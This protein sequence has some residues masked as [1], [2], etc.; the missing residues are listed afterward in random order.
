MTEQD[1]AQ[2]RLAFSISEFCQLH[3]L[4]RTTYYQME[5]EGKAPRV[6]RVGKRVLISAE[7]AADWR[8]AMERKQPEAA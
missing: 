8:S 2:L 4:G 5:R 7:A 1:K 3:G 6:M